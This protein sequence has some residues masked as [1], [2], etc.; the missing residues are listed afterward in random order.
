[1]VQQMIHL[2]QLT[3]C[4]SLANATHL[5]AHSPCVDYMLTG[6]RVSVHG[7][8][9]ISGSETLHQ[10]LTAL[11]RLPLPV[12]MCKAVQ[13]YQVNLSSRSSQLPAAAMLLPIIF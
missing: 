7:S 10:A 11:K 1:M 5:Y 4:L 13:G 8:P 6:L 9:W 2:L 12:S 3:F